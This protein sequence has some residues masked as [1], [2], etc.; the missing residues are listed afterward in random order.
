MEYA[1]PV[2]PGH[3]L[4]LPVIEGVDGIVFIVIATEAGKRLLPHTLVAYIESVPFD[5]PAAKLT[6]FVK[7]GVLV[8]PLKVA[9]VP[10]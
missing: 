5:A 8:P 3:T 9:P 7:E 10:L 6:V 2:L 1:L 4:L